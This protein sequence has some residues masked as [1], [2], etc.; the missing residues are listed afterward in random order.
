MMNRFSVWAG[1]V[2]ILVGTLALA[3][4]TR[5]AGRQGW[6][7][8]TTLGCIA[9]ELNLD[10]IQ[11]AQMKSIWNS[12]EPAVAKLVNEFARENREMQ[13]LAAQENP[14]PKRL[15][16]LADHQGATFSELVMEKEKLMM[17][18]EK[19]VLKPDQRA[20]VAA[21]ENCLDGRVD[22]FAQHLSY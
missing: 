9:S 13:A 8:H 3:A 14:D 4:R 20:K 10:N 15:Q 16:S 12:E 2:L 7:R 18:F 11:Q 22:E 21:F 6:Q 5:A 19:Q 1:A 17:Q